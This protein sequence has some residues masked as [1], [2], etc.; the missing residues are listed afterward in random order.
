MAA[1]LTS[2]GISFSDGTTMASR[3]DIFP[4]GTDWVFFQASAPTGWTKQTTHNNKALRLVSG[5]G[6][7]SGGSQ[8]F[9]T[10][11]S[12]TFKYAGTLTTT[13][14]S[15]NRALTTPM[16]PSHLHNQPGRFVVS[17]VPA[18]YNPAGQFTGWNGGDL[19]RAPGWSRVSSSTGNNSVSPN[20]SHNHPVS[21]SGPVNTTFSL[22]VRYMN[23]IV[24]S[25][26]G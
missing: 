5:T 21:A 14:A 25:F 22:G 24:C 3:R 20:N 16:I 26:N 7:G 15:G 2:S 23:V 11:C 12:P 8:P 19:K 17:A 10:V 18:L 4:T 6:G 1:Y 13:T 9:T